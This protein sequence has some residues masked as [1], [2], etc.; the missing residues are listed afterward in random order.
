MLEKTFKNPSD[1]KEIKSVSPKRNQT[2]IF[3]VRSDAEALIFWPLEM[4]SQLIGKDHDAGKD[5][6]QEEMKVTEDEMI[7]AYQQWI[8]V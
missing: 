2:W 3:I 5:W 1:S 4:K 7:G 6:D 8:R